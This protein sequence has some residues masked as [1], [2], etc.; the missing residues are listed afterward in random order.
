MKLK[1]IIQF[2]T[3]LPLSI[4][5]I[6]CS[7]HFITNETRPTYLDCG[8][9]VSKS[10][11]EVAIK[12]GTRTELYLNIQ[13]SKSG[14]RSIECNPTTYFSKQIGQ[15]VCFNLDEDVSTWY[16]INNFIGLIVLLILGIIFLLCC[17]S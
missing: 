11:D 6:Y 9:V 1:N 12:H 13:F 5:L 2:V 8:N 4:Y 14:F 17:I 3:L 16:E 10:S 15:N 7:Y